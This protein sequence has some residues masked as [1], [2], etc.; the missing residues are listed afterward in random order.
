MRTSLRSMSIAVVWTATMIASVPAGA[1]QATRWID[2]TFLDARKIL[3]PAEINGQDVMVQI[4]DGSE[5]SYIDKDFATSLG[6]HPETGAGSKGTVSVQVRLGDVNVPNVKALPVNMGAKRSSAI[7]QPFTL[8][9]DLFNAFAVEIDFTHHR[10]ALHDPATVT[11]PA[12]AI[13]IPLVRGLEARTVPVSIEGAS[14]VPFEVF[15]GDPVPLTVYQPYYEAHRLLEH[16]P[17]SIRLGGGLGARPQ[18]PVA[19]LARARFAGV[20]FANVPAVFPSNAVRGDS[21]DKVSGNIGLQLLSRFN[22]IIDYTHDRLYAVLDPA[23]LHAPFPKDRLGL[24]FTRHDDQLTVLFVS[25]GGPAEKAGLKVGDTVTAI[26]HKAVQEWPSSD[27][28][29]LPFAGAGTSV[30]FTIAGGGIKEVK[31]SDYF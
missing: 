8:A 16:R 26:N 24:Y 23:A 13:E 27:L 10:I 30:T 17:T 21:S 19:T 3:M 7:F 29:N 1:Q 4:I 12:G 22:L 11:K 5:T 31:E 28:A 9:D 20:D 14:P 2:F 15:L 6:L 18:E 25:P